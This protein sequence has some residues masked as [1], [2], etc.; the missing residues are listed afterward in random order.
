MQNSDYTLGNSSGSFIML[1]KPSSKTQLHLLMARSSAAQQ[2]NNLVK[3]QALQS[4]FHSGN[5][6]QLWGEARN[7][8]QVCFQLVQEERRMI[9]M[10]ATHIGPAD[11]SIHKPQLPSTKSIQS[12]IQVFV[13]I[14]RRPMEN[15]NCQK[16]SS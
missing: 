9:F 8:L 10:P 5:L 12:L 16:K 13:C 15:K 6:K 2:P 7:T 1:L 11:E 4:Q 14:Q 3:Q